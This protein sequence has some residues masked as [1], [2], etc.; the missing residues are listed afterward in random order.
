MDKAILHQFQTPIILVNNQ[1]EVIFT[2]H[3]FNEK[4]GY[5]WDELR[6]MLQHHY[7]ENMKAMV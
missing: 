7:V 1:R 6:Y 4:S 5:G 3:A 2:T